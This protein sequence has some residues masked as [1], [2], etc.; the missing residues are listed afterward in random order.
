MDQH[1]SVRGKTNL[2][3]AAKLAHRTGL[4]IV[5]DALKF[6][7]NV[8]GRF[9]VAAES[10]ATTRPDVWCEPRLADWIP[11]SHSAQRTSDYVL[12]PVL[13]SRGRTK[14]LDRI[15]GAVRC[16]AKAF[17]SNAEVAVK[18]IFH[19]R[20]AAERMI[21]CQETI[22]R[23]RTRVGGKCVSQAVTIVVCSGKRVSKPGT[24]VPFIVAIPPW[25]GC[26]SW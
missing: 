23:A 1:S 13:E 21:V 8:N 19:F 2:E 3:P 18:E 4:N 14:I 10:S 7:A 26:R 22:V 17:D 11:Q 9:I 20:S 12:V 25:R 24:Y 15:P 5:A 16:Q 6:F